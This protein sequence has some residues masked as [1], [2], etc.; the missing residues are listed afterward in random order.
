M[1]QINF[2]E[3]KNIHFIG[4]GGI[5]MS[6]L[7]EVLLSRGFAISGSDWHKSPLTD[8]LEKDGAVIY[9]GQTADHITGE[10]DAVVYTAAI[11]GDNAE[12]QRAA[13]LGIPMLSRA[14]LLGQMMKNY[15]TAIA[16]AGT[17]G[18]TTT[19][20][21]LS[22][23][24]LQTDM[25][26]TISVGGILP[27]IGGNIR[28]G[29][30]DCMLT[31]ACEYTN[32]FLEFFPT[33]AVILN[34]AEDHLDFFKDLADIRNSFRKFA[35]RVPE[36]GAVVIDTGIEN[37]AEITE[38]LPCRVI[39]VGPAPESDYRVENIHSHSVDG[40][41]FTVVDR[42]GAREEITLR[43][44]GS[45]NV[46]NALAAI[47]AARELEVSWEAIRAGLAHFGG[48]DRRFQ[49]KGQFNGVTVVDDYAHHPDEI[50]ATLTAVSEM[51]YPKVWCVFQPHTYTRT[52][53]LFEEF[54]QALSLAD[55]VVLADIFAARETDDLGISSQMLAERLREM[56]VSAHYFSTFEEIEKYLFQHC[57]NGELLITMGAGD[58]VNVGEAMVEQ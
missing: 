29:Y 45:Y 46:E 14:Q 18:K 27:S 13:E 6:G 55:E 52:K 31:E 25:D 28:I 37:Y 42:D 35:A 48:T 5:S 53:A 33:L 19:T 50:R 38:G 24:L 39:T 15:E 51:H 26:P 41:V 8:R 58:I 11:H 1:Y 12:Y 3:P 44:P 32:S 54:A 30:S 36:G 49:K 21:M 22:E 10:L 34:I 9:E 16:V 17:H 47:A 2:E 57:M 23:I 43:V 56:G 40:T 20:S 7:A 4:I